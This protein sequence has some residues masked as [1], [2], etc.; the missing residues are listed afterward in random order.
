MNHEPIR[1]NQTFRSEGDGSLR[2]AL[3]KCGYWRLL[4]KPC[5]NVGGGVDLFWHLERKAKIYKHDRADWEWIPYP[6][7]GVDRFP[8]MY[9]A[10]QALDN[11]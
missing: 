10:M 3:S 11:H 5:R 2:V 1:W 4:G 8:T 6:S 9:A 7:N